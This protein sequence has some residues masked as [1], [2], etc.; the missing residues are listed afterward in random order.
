MV[1]PPLPQSIV[2]G[3]PVETRTSHAGGR[4]LPPKLVEL[5]AQ[6][7]CVMSVFIAVTTVVIWVA[8]GALQPEIRAKQA[9]PII[10]LAMLSMV[11]IGGGV[12][13]LQGFRVLPPHTLLAIGMVFEVV[14]SFCMA[15]LETALPFDKN[16]VVRGV[17]TLA[18]WI[19]AVGLLIP[20]RPIWTLVTSLA[21]AST[22]VL[23]YEINVWRSGYEHL[24]WSRL[25]VWVGLLY[26]VALF[27][28]AASRRT[29]GMEMAVQ[30]A[31][32]LGSY[33]LNAL[34][35]QGGM[36][37]VWRATHKLLAREAAIK[38]VRPDLIAGASAR[39]IDVAI[40]RFEREAKA[41][42][43]LQS[44]N[45]VYLYDFGTSQDGSFYYV[46]EL[47]DGVSLQKLITTFG[48]QSA[49]RVV[50]IIRSMCRSLEE[51][52]RHG[53]VHRDLK[54]SNVMVCQVALDYDVVKVLDF[55]LV[56]PTGPNVRD[57]TMDGVSAGTPA[58]IAPEVALGSRHIDGRADVYAVGCVAHFL[59]T[60][61]LVFDE[62]TPTAMSLA[63]VQKEVVPLRSRTELPIP[64]ALER[65][66]LKCL[67][68]RPEDRPQSALAL[69]QLLEG[70]TEISTWTTA[71]A[72]GWWHVHLPETSSVRTCGRVPERTPTPVRVA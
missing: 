6:R 35:G 11:L 50:H 31:Q 19:L 8:L 5:A 65:I 1:G 54:P 53:L 15:L 58:Y 22:W 42:S 38:I 28:S 64:V 27:A 55:G 14:M 3:T 52:H 60:G 10:R 32:D 70:L 68:K 71:Q 7:L 30:K 13:A 2:V 59:L 20:K 67:E 33:N 21:S 25:G 47:L 23:A 40:Q 26:V 56:K 45:T 44:P 41:T 46:M 34:L 24:P 57:L 39:Q 9:D 16:D 69:S 51:A 4:R 61:T 18:P 49:S 48:P 36:G 62:S 37:E 29:Y 43:L 63:H 66:V 72:E 17:S 12:A